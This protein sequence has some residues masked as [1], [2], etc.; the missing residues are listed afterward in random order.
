MTRLLVLLSF[1]GLLLTQGAATAPE[2]WKSLAFTT[3]PLTPAETAGRETLLVPGRAS[4]A[5]VASPTRSPWINA[6][7]WR[8]MRAH[9][10]GK[11]AYD[12]PAG[13]AAL[14]TAEAFAYG[15]D[16]IIKVT[17]EDLPAV[18]AMLTF[19]KTVPEAPDLAAHDAGVADLGVIDDGTPI[20]GEV[21]NLLSRR[22]LLFE[23]LKAPSTHYKINIKVGSKE[24]PEAEAA[25]PSGFALKVRRQ[26]TDEQ[27]SLRIYGSEVVIGHLTSKGGKARLHLVNYG[28]SDVEGL[29]VRIRG[30]FKEDA[31]L[32]AGTG[33]VKLDGLAIVEGGTEFSLPRMATYAVIDLSITK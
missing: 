14:A 6:N 20:T 17:K 18:G 9:G 12:V 30:T 32:V 5:G 21:M 28:G 4:R 26:L 19:L 10:G 1:S 7:G 11:Y 27:R 22:N 13:R 2:K 15:A 31:V 23:P 25:D 16:A 29:R 33:P 24:Y 3:S 8:F